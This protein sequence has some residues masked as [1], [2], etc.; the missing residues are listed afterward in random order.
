[1]SK[2]LPKD[3]WLGTPINDNEIYDAAMAGIEQA[4]KADAHSPSKEHWKGIDQI[5]KVIEGMACRIHENPET[6]TKYKEFTPT[7]YL[8][9]LPC[10][11]G[12]TTAMIETV[13]ALLKLDYYKPVAFIIFLSRKDEIEAIVQR[14]SLDKSDYA[15]LTSD[16]HINKKYGDFYNRD[17]VRVLFT[18]Q[19]MLESRCHDGDKLKQFSDISDFYYHGKPRQVKIWDEAILPASVFTLKVRKLQQ[20][21]LDLENVNRSCY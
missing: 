16:E 10:G 12:K 21:I 2:M 8:S 5:V 18:T 15:C 7:F 9:S 3:F 6:P 13:K 19:A 14:M 17:N 11:M 4:F 20:T 1:M